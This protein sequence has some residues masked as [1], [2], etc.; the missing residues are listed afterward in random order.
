[1]QTTNCKLLTMVLN[2][3]K[4]KKTHSRCAGEF[5][6]KFVCNAYLYKVG[7]ELVAVAGEEVDYGNFNHSISTGTLTH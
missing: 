2:V 7:N 4:K 1:M 6:V 3:L 5:Y